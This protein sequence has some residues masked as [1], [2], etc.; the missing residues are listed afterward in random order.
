MNVF[1]RY[2]ISI[3]LV[4]VILVLCFINPPQME[5]PPVT[6]FDKLVH[7]LMFFGLSGTIFFDSSFYFKRR[8]GGWLIFWSSLLFPTVFG[9]VIEIAQEYLTVLRTGDWIDFLFDTI[10]AACGYLV[11]LIIN[12]RIKAG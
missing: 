9:G 4:V 7:F 10:G 1:K 2:W 3:L 12:G 6:N 8:A 5:A 11:C